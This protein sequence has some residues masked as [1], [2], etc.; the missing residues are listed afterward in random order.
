MGKALQYAQPHN[1]MLKTLAVASVSYEFIGAKEKKYLVRFFP[2]SEKGQE[3]W[4]VLLYEIDDGDTATH[5]ANY[6][7]ALKP[8]ERIARSRLNR[9]L[10]LNRKKKCCTQ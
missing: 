5:I 9:N 8:T 7:T 4:D 10:N 3:G 6:R 2:F 1:N